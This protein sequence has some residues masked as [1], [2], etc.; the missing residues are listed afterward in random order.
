MRLFK[1]LFK[2]LLLLFLLALFFFFGYYVSV[3]KD[4]SLSPEKLL[5]HHQNVTIYDNENQKVRFGVDSR[6]KETTPV[7]SL[8][9]KTKYAFIEIEDKRFL[10]HNGFDVKR[11]GKALLKNLKSFSFKEGASTISQQLIKNTHLS[12]EKTITRKLREFKLTYQLEKKYSKDEI[13]EKYLNTIYF[14]HNCFGI[15][16]ASNYYFNK[17]PRDLT[18]AEASTLAGLVKSPNNY[19]PFNHADKCLERRN[20]VLNALY[21]AGRITKSEKDAAQN[22]PLPTSSHENENSRYIS[23]VFKELEEISERNSLK[24]G[25]NVKIYTYLDCKLQEFFNTQTKNLDCDYSISVLDNQSHGYKAFVGSAGN[26]LRSPASLIKPLLVYA[27]AIEEN[28]ISLATPILDEK[29]NI[30]G[31]QPNNHDGKYH[32]YVSAKEALSQSLNIPSIKILNSIGIQKAVNYL[33]KTGLKLDET[34]RSLALALGGV[35]KGFSLNELVSAYSVF[36]ANGKYVS[37]AFIQKI[38]INDK[39][40]YERKTE[41]TNVF[42]EETAYLITNSLQSCVKTGTAKKLSGL[43]FDVAA[44]TGTNG[45]N[46]GNF[47]AYTIS[48]TPLDTIGVWLGNKDNSSISHS[49][50]GLPC[51]I[52]LETHKFLK[53]QYQINN[54]NIPSFSRPRGVNEVELDQISYKKEQKLL[55]ADDYA[56]KE[57]KFSEL[58]KNNAIPTQK[59]SLFSNPTIPLPQIQ[60]KDGKITITLDVNT[61]SFYSFLIEKQYYTTHKSYDTHSTLYYGNY[62]PTF[63]DQIEIGESFNYIITP[64]YKNIKGKPLSLPTISYS[65][66]QNDVSPTSPPEISKKDWWNY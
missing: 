27:P 14:G 46:K 57:Y 31:Y 49:G 10:S 22:E 28:Y 16:S 2:I 51:N 61:P 52:S 30:S 48:Y 21:K 34:D 36:P 4:V 18:I 13:L 42:S 62:K 8:S 26:L 9:E 60:S 3:T 20:F 43:K 38:I 37:P 53:K 23:A 47:D 6:F 24:L 19:S 40:V 55:L 29:I 59:A 5:I 33:E 65:S 1:K 12:Q 63:Y 45:S 41:E 35:K 15:N 64:I 66:N 7:S 39:V 17:S 54:K 56:P 50:G 32:G 58:F 25:G 11:I 44:K